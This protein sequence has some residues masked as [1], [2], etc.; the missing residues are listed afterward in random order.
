MISLFQND[1]IYIN[2]N[3]IYED[4]WNYDYAKILYQKLRNV[5]DYLINNDLEL[6]KGT[7]ILSLE[8]NKQKRTDEK[9]WCGGNGKMLAVN[10]SG[11]FYP[12]IRY[13]ESSLGKD[14]EP[15][16]I[17]NVYDGIGK[18]ETE[19]EKLKN[20]DITVSSQSTQECLDC[21]ISNGCGWC[22]AYNYQ[23]YGTVNKR[24]TSICPMHKARVLANYYYQN[25]VYKK[26]NESTR[27][28]FD[29]DYTEALKI[30]D[31][32]ELDYLL[33]LSKND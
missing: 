28:S 30:I 16:V 11:N 5:A 10:Y 3:C 22:T 17:G 6:T 15:Y 29:L 14:I 26:H 8:P 32:N 21:P 2:A 13:M 27:F 4:V 24:C 33:E 20:L 12:C 18:T 9:N 31:Q 1:Y 19:K 7:S 23:L 25:K